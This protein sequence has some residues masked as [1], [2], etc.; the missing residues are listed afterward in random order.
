MWNE[1]KDPTLK[2]TTDTGWGTQQC[3]YPPMSVYR[4]HRHL[5]VVQFRD[6]DAQTRNLVPFGEGVVD[7]AAVLNTLQKTGF[8]GYVSFEEVF[9]KTAK[10]DLLP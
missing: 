9:V 1:L 7:V 10:A 3:E 6:V 2:L 8:N 5:K 4:A